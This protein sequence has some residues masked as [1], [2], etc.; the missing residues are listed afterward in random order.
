MQHT[1]VLHN[2]VINLLDPQE[3]EIVL[4]VTLGLGGHSS[5]FLEK[6]GSSG[7][8]LA[9][10]A[11]QVNLDIAKE[12]L[13]DY[14]GQIDLR[15]NNFCN[16]AQMEFPQVDILF[17][18]LGLS[19]PHLDDPQRGFS[20]R[21]DAPLD[22][23]FDRTTGMP[24]S[25]L[26]ASLDEQGLAQIFWTYGELKSGRKLARTIKESESVKTT[27]D[28][29]ECTEKAV[30]FHAKT[31][32]PQVFQA[33]RIA[34]NDEMG[35]LEILLREGPKLLKSGGRMG[36]ITFHSLEDRMVK[37]EFKVL[38]TPE[39]DPITGADIH[40]ALFE[41]LTKKPIVP[42]EE[43]IAENPRARSAKLRILRVKS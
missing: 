34:V 38:A 12:N 2:E 4:D 22:M 40:E 19:S 6:I 7:K 30:G 21:E 29:K 31:M 42:S 1:P 43:E 3:G 13:S 10:E 24:A 16:I 32:L 15:H 8:L 37:Q 27:F 28:L 25:Q 11:D 26:I 41:I 20:F 9:I 39:K 35:S 5:L 36:V 33:L 18:D 14:S 23:R 17:A